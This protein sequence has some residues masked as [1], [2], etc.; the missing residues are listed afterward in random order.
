MDTGR[1]EEGNHTHADGSTEQHR[2]ASE[3][4]RYRCPETVMGTV[5]DETVCK[6]W[7]QFAL[8]NTQEGVA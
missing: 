1:V 4:N 8:Y 2:E 5:T 3:R 6:N 7:A